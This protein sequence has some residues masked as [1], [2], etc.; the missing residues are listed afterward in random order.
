MIPIT[1]LS[2]GEEEVAAAAE[3]IRSGWLSQ[4]KRVQQFEEAVASYVGARHAIATNSCTTALHLSL[5]A[6]GVQPGDEVIC[7]SF[8][9]IASANAVL[10]AGANPVFVDIDPQT[11]NIDVGHVEASI[12]PR[13]SAI[14]PVSQIGLAAD[15]PALLDIGRQHGVKVVEDAAPSL[16][17]T[18]GEALLG[19][20]SDFTC[21]SFDARKIL[22]TGEGGMITTNDGEAAGRLRALRAHA[23]SVSAMDRHASG[24]IG[25]EEYS[26][27]GFNYKMT[28]IQAAIGVVQMAKID[29]IVRERRRL[30]KRYSVLLANEERLITPVEP[31]HTRH[32]YQSYC[33]RLRTGRP[34]LE[35]MDSLAARGV[36]SRRIMAIHLEPFYRGRY[37]GLHLPETEKAARDTLLLP[38]FTG[39]TEDEQDQVVEA[40]LGSLA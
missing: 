30:A 36:A 33:V 4:G 32:V 19:S 28:D 21:F 22:T 37:P 7:P 1:R 29:A 27:L 9:F 3:A 13:T 6:A 34:Q 23:A 31:A 18:I 16:G 17:A 20:L 39:L 5:I 24:G 15:I 38:M 11:Y 35:V 2:V 26:E 10:Y 8:S 14:L 12:T 40:L 25:L